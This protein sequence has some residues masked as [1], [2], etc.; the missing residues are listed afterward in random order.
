[1]VELAILLLGFLRGT[2][3]T[4][5]LHPQND[6][7]HPTTSEIPSDPVNQGLPGG[8]ALQ[9]FSSN[10]LTFF[11]FSNSAVQQVQ[12]AHSGEEDE[13]DPQLVDAKLQ[14]AC[15][16]TRSMGLL[17]KHATSIASD[18]DNAPAGLAAMDD[19]ETTYLQP[20][21]IIDG[22]LEKIADVWPI[23]VDW[24]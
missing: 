8:P 9:V 20:L 1:M 14:G 16:G 13:H 19:F 11:F 15:D 10:T 21:K 22:I 23:L 7:K 3:D 4:L 24:K 18:A 2:Q 5:H 12:V 17:G 6:N